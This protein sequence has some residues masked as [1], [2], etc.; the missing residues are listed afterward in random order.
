MKWNLQTRRWSHSPLLSN[1]IAAA[2]IHTCSTP[3]SKTLLRAGYTP[4]MWFCSEVPKESNKRAIIMT[5]HSNNREAEG[6]NLF[7]VK[8]VMCRCVV[9]LSVCLKE[10]FCSENAYATEE[11][12]EPNGRQLKPPTELSSSVTHLPLP[13]CAPAVP[14]RPLHIYWA[15]APK[16]GGNWKFWAKFWALGAVWEPPWTRSRP[17]QCC[18]SLCP[19]IL[20][21][22]YVSILRRKMNNIL[23]LWSFHI[24]RASRRPMW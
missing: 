19:P 10:C 23:H 5:S 1:V 11:V 3:I 8:C 22:S 13:L 15:P 17:H 14:R 20:F 18:L 2:A 6:E 24:H 4:E 12:G 7:D 9:C 21:V 16:L